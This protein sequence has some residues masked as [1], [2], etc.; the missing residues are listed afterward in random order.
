MFLYGYFSGRGKGFQ[1]LLVAYSFSLKLGNKL[2]SLRVSNYVYVMYSKTFNMKTAQGST[3]WV[4]I[5]D[6]QSGF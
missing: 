4:V 6:S 3:E 1:C 2:F 5:H